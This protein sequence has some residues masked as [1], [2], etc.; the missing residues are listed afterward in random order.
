MNAA[1]QAASS[2]SGNRDERIR[3][4]QIRQQQIEG[5]AGEIR[6]LTERE[7]AGAAV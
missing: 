7:P 2:F 1:R 3:V 6:A 5:L 4:L